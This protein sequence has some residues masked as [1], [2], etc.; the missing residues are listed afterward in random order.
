MGLY[1]IMYVTLSQ[2]TSRGHKRFKLKER[3]LLRHA[4]VTDTLSL[5]GEG[6]IPDR[7]PEN[8]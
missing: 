1:N 2:S 5:T 6:S 8:T 4:W 7:G 3:V